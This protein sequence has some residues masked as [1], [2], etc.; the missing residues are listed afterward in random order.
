MDASYRSTQLDKEE[1]TFLR[2][3]R[4]EQF[5]CQI[6]W[7]VVHP[8]RAMEA[9]NSLQENTLQVTHKGETLPL[10]SKNWREL[11]LKIFHLSPKRHIQGETWELHELFPSLKTLQKGQVTVKFSDCQIA[12]SKEPLR[13]LSSFFYHNTASQYSIPIHFAKLVVAAVNG[14]AVDWPL[15]FFD[16]FKAEVIAM[17]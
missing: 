16:K 5:L 12:G 8:I 7:E 11:F 14:Q 10:F 4:L 6:P 17:H 9:I 15:E 13:L 2:K 3:L 1:L